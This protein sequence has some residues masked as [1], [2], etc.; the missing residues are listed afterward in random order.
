MREHHNKTIFR[1]REDAQRVV[2][3]SRARYARGEVDKPLDHEYL[4]PVHRNHYHVS[5]TAASGCALLIVCGAVLAALLAL[6]AST[7]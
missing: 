6:V 4:C 2:A 1:S 5:S 3:G 7:G